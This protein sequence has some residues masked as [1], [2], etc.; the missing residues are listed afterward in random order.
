MELLYVAVRI[1]LTR[2]DFGNT[3]DVLLGGVV[4]AVIKN[5]NTQ[6]EV[7]LGILEIVFIFLSKK[8]TIW[9]CIF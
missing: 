6:L 9:V 3:N 4:P 7:F 1:K 8:M 5:I 2:A